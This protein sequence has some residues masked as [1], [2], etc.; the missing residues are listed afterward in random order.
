MQSICVHREMPLTSPFTEILRR[1]IRLRG[2]SMCTKKTY[3][4]WMRNFI[5][6][7][8]LSGISKLIPGFK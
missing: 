6:K 5:D 4:Y 3:L 8:T 2:Y 1:D 7:H